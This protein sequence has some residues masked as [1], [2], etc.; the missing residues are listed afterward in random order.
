MGLFVA[1]VLVALVLA[2]RMHR[3]GGDGLRVAVFLA[4]AFYALLIVGFSPSLKKQTFLPAYPLLILVAVD[5]LRVARWR[6][7]IPAAACLGLLVHQFSEAAPWR[8]G[9]TSQR[10]LLR[11]VLALTRPGE[12]V[13][14]V[15]GETVFRPRPLYFVFVQA[16]MRGI[17]EGRLPQPD[18]KKL[19][20][21]GTP[22]AIGGGAGF[23][24][25]LRK[26]VKDHYATTRD[27]VLRV[28]GGSLEQDGALWQAELPV[29]GDYVLLTRRGELVSTVRIAA[30]GV[31]M[32]EVGEGRILY[33]KRA[34]DAG[35]LPAKR[36]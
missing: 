29:A 20:A 2:W 4:A 12:P 14:D 21:S 24:A 31:Q 10:E 8:D 32:L 3:T 25:A 27:G 1:G 26:Y 19:A 28:A 13:L 35:V 34:W 16:T 36:E 9:M 15:K 11:S 18:L 30:S 22:V 33:W 5:V 6:P 7:W 17:E 23:P